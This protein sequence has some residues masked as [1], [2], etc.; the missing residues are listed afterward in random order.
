MTTQVPEALTLNLDGRD[1]LRLWRLSEAIRL[2]CTC[3]GLHPP[4][5]T[6]RSSPP[7]ARS[8]TSTG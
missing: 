8:Q 5:D 7:H 2:G 3:R 4:R 6:S 1:A